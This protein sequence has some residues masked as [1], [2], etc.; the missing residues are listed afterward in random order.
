MH[1]GRE[2][3]RGR[4]NLY[5]F[6]LWTFLSSKALSWSSLY[7]ASV[8]FWWVVNSQNG[9]EFEVVQMKRIFGPCKTW[10]GHC[11]CFIKKSGKI[12]FVDFFGNNEQTVILTQFEKKTRFC[13]PD[14]TR[15][16]HSSFARTT[17][18]LVYLSFPLWCKR[19]SSGKIM[20]AITFFLY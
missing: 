19:Q 3:E 5:S 18:P 12:I 10:K 16:Q 14:T 9:K 13:A 20:L 15:W 4:K 8:L 1:T 17:M 11:M 2:R 6:S 7:L